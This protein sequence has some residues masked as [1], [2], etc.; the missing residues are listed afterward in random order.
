MAQECLAKISFQV[1]DAMK[2]LN[3]SGEYRVGLK[4]L[5]DLCPSRI[6]EK[7]TAD[8][9]LKNWDSVHK[10]AVTEVS[11]QL[12]EFE[13]KN[14]VAASFQLKEKL[15][16]EDLDATIEFLTQHEKKVSDLKI[17]YDCVLFHS[18]EGWIA[19][20]DTTESGDLGD[21][22]LIHE[23]TSYHEMAQVDDFLSISINVHDDG[24]ILEIV[25]MCSSHGTHVASIASGYHPDDPNLNGI[26]PAAKIISLTIG[27]GR[28]GSMETG[29]S[30]VR[31]IIKVMELCEQG[32]KVDVIN[33]SY[34]EHAHWSNAGRVGELM[35]EL[36]NRY[37]VVWV[38]SAG[39][40]GPALCTVSTPPDIAQ[41]NLIG[42]GAYVSPDMMEAEYSLR[43]KLPGN[44][45]TWTSRDPCI[46]GAFGI[47]VCAP[48]AAIASVPEFAMAK[49]QLMNGT[50]MAA[51]HVAGAVALLIS[52]LKQKRIKYTPYS[53]KQALWNT[54]TKIDYV[55]TFAQ[56][57]GLL[58]VE[59]AFEN[60][61]EYKGRQ[62]NDVRFSIGVG[63]SGAKGIHIRNGVLSKPEE[64]AVT[65]E[66]VMFNEKFASP[67]SKLDFNIHC[68]LVPTASWLQC[69]TFLDLCY[70]ARSLT[71]R[72]DPT[73]L[74]IGVHTARVN[75]YDSSCVEKGTIFEIPVTVVQPRA[76]D[77]TTQYEYSPRDAVVCKP[78]TIIR[79]FFVVPRH[80]T[81][82]GKL[83]NLSKRKFQS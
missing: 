75:A 82:A 40:H 57:N 7:I 74:P 51:P 77:A 72:V 61:C 44:V 5:A 46:D 28:L 71:V 22:L 78:N 70:T 30:I 79:E 3:P 66:P 43:Q 24:N 14:P 12:E 42:V 25:G 1:S 8:S 50:S 55:D 6:R 10:R 54:A 41:R 4:S 60:L 69:G 20:L 38:A 67:K 16:K 64:F 52:G 48:G 63:T 53:I 83:S 68:T 65:I 35:N 36:V 62:E 56:G 2:A 33:M 18:A 59:K 15:Q 39:N 73:G 81:W 17:S 31:A 26:A 21:A 58:N 37:G 34:G 19:V 76:L 47:T 11:K 9:K 49:A 45:Y 80:A 23:Y 27:E 13:S 32:Q 29:T